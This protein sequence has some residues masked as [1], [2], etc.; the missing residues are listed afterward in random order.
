MIRSHLLQV[1]CVLDAWI[2]F[3]CCSLSAIIH[4]FLSHLTFAEDLSYWWSLQRP[5]S[6]SCLILPSLWPVEQSQNL[7][8]VLPWEMCILCC[9]VMAK[10]EGLWNLF[11]PRE[12]DPETVVLWETCI[13]CCQVM[14]KCEGL[15][16]LF[17]PRETDPERRYGAGLTNVEYVFI[18]EEMGKSLIAPEVLTLSC[19]YWCHLIIIVVIMSFTSE[20]WRHAG[21]MWS[22]CEL[23]CCPLIW[24]IFVASFVEIFPLITNILCNAK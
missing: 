17:L 6:A 23:W 11:L 4:V 10:C 2:H 7:C 24:W 13:L 21:V 18:C 8:S 19:L 20:A 15:W 5:C 1:V 16:N 12:T 3:S 9:Q 22:G 14:A